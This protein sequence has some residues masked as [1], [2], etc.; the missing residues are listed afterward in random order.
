M[1]DTHQSDLL[2]QD[3]ILVIGAESS[4]LDSLQKRYNHFSI[5]SSSSIL[6]G[7]AE[8]SRKPARAIIACISQD[9]VRLESAL[10]NLREIAGSGTRIVLCCNPESEPRVRRLVSSGADDYILLPL[11]ESEL[12]MALGISYPDMSVLKSFT[13]EPSI[14]MAELASLG[15]VLAHLDEEPSKVLQRILGL[16]Q[17]AVQTEQVSICI[18]GS[19]AEGPLNGDELV[20]V[21]PLSMDG[22]VVG[23]IGLGKRH[24]LAFTQSD[25]QKVRHYARLT[26]Y[27]LEAANR[28]RSWRSMAMTDEITGLPN[29]RQLIKKLEELIERASNEQFR[30]TFLLFDIDNFK[31]YNDQY[32]H[33][34]GD[35]VLKTI[36][37][38]FT[39]HSREHDM[40]ARYGGDEFAVIFWDADRPRVPGSRHPSE[41]IAVLNRYKNALVNQ[42]YPMLGPNARGCLT[43]SGGLASFPWDAQ[44]ATD[45]IHA[46]D[47]ALLKAKQ[48]GKNRFHLIGNEDCCSDKLE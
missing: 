31:I 14:T 23:R 32:G 34:V 11:R 46:A 21:E 4:L 48:A 29:R 6:E 15:D 18:N 47:Q 2:S 19:F 30:I 12:D 7:I 10:G 45:L 37:D 3:R 24:G 27:I 9:W 16:I 8:L 42:E 22:K 5:D 38:L 40:V 35:K 13:S 39:N 44:G 43:I 25:I 28:H 36:A 17:T 33:D 20:L 1:R 26:G 41:A